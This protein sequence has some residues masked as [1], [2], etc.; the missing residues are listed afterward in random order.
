MAVAGHR[1]HA[2]QHFR[3]EHRAVGADAKDPFG[4][5]GLRG[6]LV[7]RQH[8]RQIAPDHRRAAGVRKHRDR[9][10][11]RFDTRGDDDA[12]GADHVFHGG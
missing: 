7:A 2:A 5:N 1:D 8:V 10:I 6:S 3:I 11:R 4:L 12:R 9:V